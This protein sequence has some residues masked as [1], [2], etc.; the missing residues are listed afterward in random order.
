MP[1]LL[2]RWI[3]PFTITRTLSATDNYQL[4]L[5][6][7]YGRLH[8]VFHTSQ[9]KR[10]QENNHSKFPGRTLSKPGPLPDYSENDRFNIDHIR[11]DRYIRGRREFL[12][13]WEGYGP[14]DDS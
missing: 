11:A 2:P 1:K 4:A 6:A 5:P 14:E 10:W 13:R 7:K 9:L 8:P 3:G 12:I